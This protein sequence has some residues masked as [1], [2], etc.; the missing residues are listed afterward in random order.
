MNKQFVSAIRNKC[1]LRFIYKGEERII[2]PQTYG[3]S[4]TGKEVLRARQIGGG[5]QSDEARIAKLFDVEKISRLK[6]TR[7]R[8]TQA[9]PE[10]NP[11]DSAMKEIFATLLKPAVN[12]RS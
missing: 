8:F 12:R 1:V 2:E 3:V 6:K 4:R 9:L 11:D 5:S 10:H 7:S